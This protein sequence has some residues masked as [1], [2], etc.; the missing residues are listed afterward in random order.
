MSSTVVTQ[1]AAL[2]QTLEANGWQV[3]VVGETD[4]EAFGFAWWLDEAWRLKSVWSPTDTK[5][6][7]L[8]TIDPQTD[9]S[10]RR[11]G[12]GVSAVKATLTLATQPYWH[13]HEV[14]LYLKAGWRD[15]LPDFINEVALFRNSQ[16]EKS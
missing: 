15:A 10:K 7:L 4:A 11:K 13:D 3:E 6:Y 1:K 9:T 8:F 5:V 2:M 14:V 12:E 16:A